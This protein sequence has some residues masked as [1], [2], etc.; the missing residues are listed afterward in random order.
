M[1]TYRLAGAL[2]ATF[3]PS[4]LFAQDWNTDEA[5]A[6]VQRGI[7]RRAERQADSS[8]R[9]YRVVAHGF[10]FFLGQLAE[11]MQEP[12][13]LIK[14]DEL[15]L[16][17][18]WKAPGRSK[19]QIVGWRDR[20]DLPTDIQYHRD[21]L[22][23]VQ[24]NFGDRIRLGEGDEVRDVIHPLA[25]LGPSVYDYEL[26][27]DLTLALPNRTVRAQ[28]VRVR[29]KDFSQARV[30]GSLF[31]DVETAEVVIFQFSF[32]RAAYLDNTLEDITIT[33]ENGLFQGRYWLPWRQEIEIRRRTKWLDMPA[34]GIIRGRW[35]IGDYHFNVGLPDG[36]FTG[37]EIQ[38]LPKAVR[39]TFSWNVPLRVAIQEAAGPALTFDLE[40]VHDRIA[41][42]AGT[43]T[44]SGL[45]TARPAVG[46]V[47]DLLHF[48]R[49]EGLAPGIGWIFRPSG[50]AVE[51]EVHGSVGA[52]DE[53]PKGRVEVRLRAG[54]FDFQVAA[55]R[56]LT[57]VVDQ[58]TI[59]PVLNSLLAQEAG[60]DYG[61]YV[62]LDRAELSVRRG[63][64]TRGGVSVGAGV[65]RAASVAVMAT[66]ASGT[67]RPNAALGAQTL[68]I[69]RLS[70]ERQSTTLE[71]SG[72]LSARLDAEA[73]LGDTSRYVRVRVQGR[74][75]VELGATELVLRTWGG[76]GSAG[77]PP[78]RTFVMGGRG[79]LVGEPYRAWGGRWAGWGRLEWRLQLPVPEIG[80]GPY[81]STGR[82]AVLAPF[83]AAGWAGGATAG[84]P[85]QPSA[86]IRPVA[87]VAVE[88]FHR[89]LRAEVGVS[90]RSGD[91]GATLGVT[92][93]LWDIL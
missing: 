2:L 9:D 1:P 77:M 53:R 51:I 63:F 66:P 69:A 7:E 43:H 20:I 13:R 11:G 22:G 75:H 10:V 8:L 64:G 5:L 54:R 34:R 81:V 21:H 24:N 80:L 49:V 70:L 33:L 28:E 41:E 48:N 72:G 55:H 87:G 39:D 27:D 58:P 74:G 42:L 73:G 16:R 84:T 37:P 29:P 67:F 52:S 82:R 3:L 19:Q 32:T 91:I 59:A 71:V 68:G 56:R 25:R 38:P 17:V 45:A 30:V 90:L 89:F 47:S 26:G 76:W 44:L 36:L 85:W 23:I 12:P 57:D 50:D 88:W 78:Y 93:D 46:S 18:Y 65:E 62:L 6:L 61:D 92:P 14:S 31:I 40:E 83:V 15:M 4:T 86:A 35:E 60:L 79:T